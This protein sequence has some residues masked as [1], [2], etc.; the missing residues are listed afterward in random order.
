MWDIRD[1]MIFEL[2]ASCSLMMRE[3]AGHV[4]ATP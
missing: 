1:L 4:A 2:A 3:F